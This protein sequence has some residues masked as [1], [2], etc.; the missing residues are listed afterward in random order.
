LK[1]QILFAVLLSLAW[2]PAAKSGVVLGLLS[3]DVVIPAGISSPGISAFDIF[4]FTGAAYGPLAGLPYAADS[5]T[6]DNVVLTALLSGG[7]EQTI[8]LGDIGPGELLE[9]NGSPVVQVPGSWQ[10]TSATLTGTLSQPT[11]TLSDGSTFTASPSISVSLTP[12]SGGLLT[13]GVD[14]SPIYAEAATGAVPEPGT[15]LSL[16]L[17]LL[18]V[19]AIRRRRLRQWKV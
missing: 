10:F 6:L 11:F 12:S 4:D 3:F 8:D 14:F 16:P 18:A 15:L 19:A 1:R 17:G 7:G 2:M 13:A 9:S 5:L